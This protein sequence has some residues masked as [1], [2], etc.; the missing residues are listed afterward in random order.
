[1][2]VEIN[3]S[4]GRLQTKYKYKA[5]AFC[6]EGNLDSTCRATGLRDNVSLDCIPA[7]TVSGFKTRRVFR[8]PAGAVRKVPLG[9]G[10]FRLVP[11]RAPCY[12]VETLKT[13]LEHP[14]A[15]KEYPTTKKKMY[16]EDQIE[17]YSRARTPKI[18]REFDQSKTNGL[19][20][21][22]TDYFN[23][24]GYDDSIVDKVRLAIA[25]GADP[26]AKTP[27]G[28]CLLSLVLDDI[29]FWEKNIDYVHDLRL[30]SLE[31]IL[32]TLL[33]Q[34]ANPN[35]TDE[36]GENI[37]EIAAKNG[38]D[39]DVLRYI[40]DA[41]ADP[42]LSDAA[43][44]AHSNKHPAHARMIL[45]KALA[46][47]NRV[48]K[49]NSDGTTGLMVAAK[50]GYFDIVKEFVNAGATVLLEDAYDET[51][52]EHAAI[53]SH[54]GIARYLIE[55]ARQQQFPSLHVARLATQYGYADLMKDVL[56]ENEFNQEA[57]DELLGLTA[58]RI[59][60]NNE[61]SLEVERGR[62]EIARMLLG[63]GANVHATAVDRTTALNKA[64]RYGLLSIVTVLLDA[65]GD[66]EYQDDAAPLHDPW[67]GQRHVLDF[68]LRYELIYER[69]QLWDDMNIL[70][71]H[72][73]TPL[74]NAIEAPFVS[75]GNKL[76]MTNLL[77]SRGANP[78][79]RSPRGFTALMMAS[80]T[81]NV[82][83]ANLLMQKGA[84]LEDQTK[85]R[86]EGTPLFAKTDA[87][88]KGMLRMMLE[89]ERGYIADEI[90]GG[91]AL[92]FASQFGRLGVV[93][94]LLDAGCNPNAQDA[95]GYTALMDAA[96]EGHYEVCEL[97]LA[98]GSNLNARSKT[99]STAL[100]Q[101]SAN[102]H[103]RVVQLL[104]QT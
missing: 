86:E 17:I 66:I 93:T 21:M 79:T 27:D 44:K 64:A 36:V 53:N 29:V 37:L 30:W 42:L 14:S 54:Y 94:A 32:Q 81:G 61:E 52:I 47:P 11:V 96:R 10:S 70:R 56:Q 43:E 63:A 45:R 55:V 8:E 9:D 18:K 68:E 71:I 100:R 72:G 95:Y 15:K 80:I 19:V 87:N 88:L 76:Q 1:M 97:L 101:A 39:F 85:R 49:W 102:K 6:S 98:R 5:S 57:K 23:S 84:S 83:I 51:A 103:E 59:H 34:G 40:L 58:S 38:V 33:N 13:I 2:S 91:T 22:L 65:G 50:L 41:R 46:K 99:G 82:P 3:S 67:Y 48:S 26:N 20:T 73:G 62:E 35:S 89:R 16:I 104:T 78:N 28:G 75:T 7:D 90:R 77:L 25:K 74:V 60:G 69:K 12:D 24:D 92:M 31:Q 4:P